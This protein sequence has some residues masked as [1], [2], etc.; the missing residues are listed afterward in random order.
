MFV[1]PA[2]YLDRAAERAEYERHE[3]HVDDPGYRRFLA[4][5]AEPLQA[6]LPAA[7]HGLDFGCGP[8]PALATMLREAGHRVACYDSF[9]HPEERVLTG[10]YDFVTATEVVEHLHQPGAELERLWGL[11]RPGGWLALMTKLVIDADAFARWHYIR[12]P[13][14][15]CFFSAETFHWWASRHAAVPQR[16]AD[17]VVLLRKPA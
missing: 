15:V 16:C 13:T 1:P 11:L 6:R 9:F 12:D 5:L 10:F 2:F 3:N 7:S 4:R 17:D 8:A 14:H